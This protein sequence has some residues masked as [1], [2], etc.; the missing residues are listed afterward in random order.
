MD[1]QIESL[2][3]DFATCPQLLPAQM[4]AVVAAG[5]KS[6]INNRPDQEGGAE[7]PG[8][9]DIE[10]AAL[11]AGLRYA[12]LPVIPTDINPQEVDRMS[13]LIADLPKPVLGFC[14]SGARAAK[15][16][17]LATGA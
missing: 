3:A 16:Y 5:F 4:A 2:N 10:R 7:Q 13:A 1:L 12:Y 14:R 9:A 8:S 17:R 6:V 11:A 15:L